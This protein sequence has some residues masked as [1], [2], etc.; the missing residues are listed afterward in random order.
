M[1]QEKASRES[2][3]KSR[4]IDPRIERTQEALR[5]V[6]MALIE[7][8][9]YDVISVQEITDRARLN[10]ATF[11]LH[12]RDKQDLLIHW[13][14]AVFD[15]LV[16][17]AGPIDREN[18]VLQKPPRQLVVVFKHVAEYRDFYRVVLGKSGVP[19][20][21]AQ[22]REYLVAFTL[23]R[24]DSLRALYPDAMPII[25]DRFISEYVAGALLG[26]IIWWLENGLP[27]SPEYMAD[28]FSWLT[29]AGTYRMMGIEPPSPD[30]E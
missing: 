4:K 22:M 9:G 5:S 29:I 3:T 20:F 16:E 21:A 18:L 27:H 2:V 7:E 13:S 10:R 30:T 8:K 17:E 15:R 26:I 12:Y 6:F 14:E 23:A 24:F 19:A 28:R 11:Y 1:S 25:D